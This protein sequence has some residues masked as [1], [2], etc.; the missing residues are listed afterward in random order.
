MTVA[1]RASFNR[2]AFCVAQEDEAGCGASAVAVSALGGDGSFSAS[3]M[4]PAAG[5][6]QMLMFLVAPA[7]GALTATQQ[8]STF[9]VN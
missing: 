7:G 5:R 4:P 1:N 8:L 2:V 6:Y 9:T 3:V